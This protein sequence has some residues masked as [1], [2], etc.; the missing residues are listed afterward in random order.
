M[1]AGVAVYGQALPTGF[2][3]GVLVEKP[4]GG[5]G[6]DFSLRASGDAVYRFHCDGKTWI[7][8]ENERVPASGL[9]AGEVVEVV[10]DRDPNALYSSHYAR[11]IHVVAQS[12]P[13][14]SISTE[15]YR[16]YRPNANKI[17]Y[18][19]FNFSYSGVIVEIV[20]ERMVLRTRFDGQKVIYLRPDTRC[21]E[22]GSEV[23]AATIRPNTRV[24]VEA[25]KDANHNLEADRVVWGGI[26]E[27]A[28]LRE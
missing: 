25:R 7:E 14:P 11:V 16:L 19:D 5:P 21:L 6:S 23:D 12:R 18:P 22:E 15:M 26:L 13:H 2:V 4:V 27:P 9:R 8:R 10:S 3:R 28:G 17:S 24:F 20:G 1:I